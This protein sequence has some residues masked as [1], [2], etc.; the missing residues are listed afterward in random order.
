MTSE[1]FARLDALKRRIDAA[2]DEAALAWAEIKDGKLYRRTREG[3]KKQTWEQYCQRVHG[4][5]P[6]W[7]NKLIRRARM[8]QSIKAK[9]ETSVSLSPTAAGHLEGLDIEEQ[10]EI[11]QEAAKENQQPR[12][13]DIADKKYEKLMSRFQ[14]GGDMHNGGSKKATQPASYKVTV[15]TS[16][17]ADL[18]RFGALLPSPITDFNA[19]SVSGRVAL[20][21]INKTLAALGNALA[22]AQPKK[23]R[24]VVEL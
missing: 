23:V 18:D 2:W 9:S 14:P 10:V 4:I 12:A 5:T 13:K 1:E 16:D 8:L 22:A 3:N 21:D 7:A 17:K 11:A 20:Q 19:H 6:Q 24:I 15:V